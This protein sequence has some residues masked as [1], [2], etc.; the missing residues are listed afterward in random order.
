M[1]TPSPRPSRVAPARAATLLRVESTPAGFPVALRRVLAGDL[2]VLSHGL[3]HLGHLPDME[4]LARAAVAHRLPGSPAVDAPLHEL[5]RH[6]D[7]RAVEAI[8]TDLETLLRPVGQRVLQDMTTALTPRE[9]RLYLSDHLG[10]R[11]MPPLGTVTDRHEL[12]S[13]DGFLTPRDAHVDSWFNTAL[14]SVNLWMAVTPVRRGNGLVLYPDVF[15]SPLRHDGHTLLPGQ[16]TGDP[17]DL[18]LDPG[19]ILLFA[20]DHLHASQPNTTDQTRFV[21]TKRFSAGPPRYPRRATG[22]VPYLD[23]R[24][25]GTRLASLAPLRSRLTPAGLRHALRGHR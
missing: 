18:A 2:V 6:A 21:V 13:L 22:W 24:L 12:S 10:I 19:D 15:R 7:T 16:D 23:Q 9:T 5:H 20:G 4:R 8:R 14:N 1:N 11:I 3:R 25:L 17:V